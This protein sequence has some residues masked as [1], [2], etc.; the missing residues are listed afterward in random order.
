MKKENFY[1]TTTLPYVNASPHI[2][3]AM[4]IIRADVVA[5]YKRH[6]GYKVFFNTGTDEHGQKLFEAAKSENISTKEYVD[7]NFLGFL[8][9]IEALNISSDTFIRTT[10]ERHIKAAQEIWRRCEDNGYIYKKNYEMKY[11]VGC[12][13]EKQNSELD[14]N[15]RCLEH[16]N[17]ELEIREEENYF[18]SF[19]KLEEKLLNFYEENPTFVIPDFRFNEIKNFVKNGLQDFSISRLKS[20][21]EWGIPVPN[22]EEHVM[23][24]WFDALTN[25]ISTLDWPK[26]TNSNFIDFWLQKENEKREVIQYCGKDNLR[27]QAATWQAMLMAAEIPNSTNIIIDGFII[28]GGQKMSKSLGNVI[29]P[30]SIIEKYKEVTDF[31]E[32]VLR[33][34]LTH[35]VANFEDSDITEDSIKN[36]YIT[37]LQNGLGNQVSRIMKLSNQYL[38]KGDIEEVLAKTEEI[39]FA[40]EYESHLNNF[41][42]NEAIHFVTNEQKKLDEYI[43]ETAPFKL[44]KSESEGDKENG[45]NIL[46]NCVKELLTIAYHLNFFMPKTSEIIFELVKENKMPEKPLFGRI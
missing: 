4:E 5:R 44:L 12:E 37:F 21:M 16:P 14:E 1:I 25:Y 26:E 46:K 42:L 34:V 31:P 43:Q 23:Y 22:D 9:L 32:E 7:K 45:K 39:S 35:E 11:C 10:E 28:S 27:Y 13:S 30:Y 3:F 33:F 36:S 18:F 29:S 2:G 40:E 20:K 6:A 24:V 19:S 17:R 8:N 15:G 41:K 38:A